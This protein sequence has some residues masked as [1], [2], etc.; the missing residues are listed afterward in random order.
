MRKK[1][2]VVVHGRFHA[3]DLAR[4]LGARGHCVNVLT[5]LPP[6]CYTSFGLERTQVSTFWFYGGLT[7]L[8]RYLPDNLIEKTERLLK[9]MFSNW[10]ARR[11]LSETY[12]PDV[13]YCFSGIAEELFNR[14]PADRPLKL[15]ARGSTHIRYQYNLLLQEE[16]RVSV[17]I[18]KPSRWMIDREEREYDLADCVVVLSTFAYES[19]LSQTSLFKATPDDVKKR[20]L[21]IKN[22]KKL[23]VLTVGSFSF[24]KGAF[25][26]A[27]V[28][29]IADAERFNFRFVGDIGGE[30]KSLMLGSKEFIEFIAKHL[31][32][33]PDS[34]VIEESTPNER[35]IELT[36]KVGSDDV[37]K[38]IG[39]QGKTAQAMRTLLTA[40]AAKEGKRAILKI[41]D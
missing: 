1:I 21:H 38:V 19:F 24:R 12:L 5:C 3:F 7:R 11:I 9:P 17:P 26:L 15:L 18:E 31:V 2:T 10:A 32:D 41:L 6:S 23:N 29:K 20:V 33:N 40:I 30:A 4:E 27:K 22:S 39:K 8:L 28:A 36:L 14:L 25:D 37:G 35:T 13:V 34:V 16:R